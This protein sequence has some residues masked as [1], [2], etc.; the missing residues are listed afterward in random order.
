MH[1]HLHGPRTLALIAIFKFAKV[2]MLIVL[3]ALL[4]HLSKPEAIG[5]F[6]DWLRT[7]PVATGHEYV[8]RAVRAV[9]DL[10]PHTIGLFAAVAMIYAV[11][12]SIE[13]YGLWQ[14]ARW[15]K[16]LTVISTS[17]FVPLELW[18]MGRHFSWSKV[19]ALVINLLIVAYL[20]HLLR[21]EIAAEHRADAERS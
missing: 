18:E 13:G 11:L 4:F 3:A 15:A 19:A 14:N 9:T 1:P 2:A 7:L 12:Y 17:L 10:D 16:Y 8:S 5:A 21:V 6:A 20:V